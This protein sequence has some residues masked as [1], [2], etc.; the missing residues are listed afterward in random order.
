MKTDSFAVTCPCCGAR[1]KVDPALSAVISHEPPPK[2]GPSRD[3]DSAFK[4]LQDKSA[5]R[6]EHFRQSVEAEKDKGKLLDRKFQEGLK[7]A[8]D[9]P[10]PPLRPID[11]D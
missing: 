11:L 9:S 7:K 2:S 8:K 3:L 5:R 4:A 1:L 6:E 10:D